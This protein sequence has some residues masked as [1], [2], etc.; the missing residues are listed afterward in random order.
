MAFSMTSPLHHSRFFPCHKAYI[1]PVLLPW[2]QPYITL[3][4]SPWHHPYIIPALSPWHHP[5]IAPTLCPW[6]R[7]YINPIF[8]KFWP[9]LR[10]FRNFVIEQDFWKFW[11]KS[12]FS[13]FLEKNRNVLYLD[14]NWDFLKFWPKSM[15]FSK[16]LPKSTVS[17]TL[18][19]IEIFRKKKIQSRYFF[20]EFRTDLRYFRKFQKNR[21][22]ST[23]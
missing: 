10:F 21:D 4:L 23:I 20:R 13:N 19:N 8:R 9:N 15:F 5:Y 18:T 2:H 22:F 6:Y 11:L 7:N 12:R 14:Q 1:I 17:K 3:A 16:F